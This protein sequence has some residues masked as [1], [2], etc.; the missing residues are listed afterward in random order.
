MLFRNEN[1]MKKDITKEL[2]KFHQL[3]LLN[4]P[5]NE[6][7]V[8]AVKRDKYRSYHHKT[9]FVFKLGDEVTWLVDVRN[10]SDLSLLKNAVTR[11]AKIKLALLKLI[12]KIKL[13]RLLFKRLHVYSKHPLNIVN[14]L[15][16]R[17]EDRFSVFLGTHAL[18]RNITIAVVR[19]NG[20]LEYAK[21]MNYSTGD[22]KTKNARIALRS[23]SLRKMN[24]LLV[25]K[26]IESEKSN[27]LH[28][29]VPNLNFTDVQSFGEAHADALAD[30]FELS[31]STS[32]FGNSELRINAQ[33]NLNLITGE[34]P[35]DRA[36][37]LNKRLFDLLQEIDPSKKIVRSLGHGDFAPWNMRTCDEG[38][39]LF[40][41]EYS[42]DKI[43]AL[44]DLIHYHFQKASIL[45][46]AD[47]NGLMQ[48][49]EHSMSF[50][51]IKRITDL[52]HLDLRTYLK[53]Y[54]NVGSCILCST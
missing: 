45:G 7:I 39:Y 8:S 2:E 28:T 49:I 1:N 48:K 24:G 43:P 18:E 3:C 40:D 15:K 51:S 10:P 16:L 27:L 53:Y 22:K 13:G 19:E 42:S 17:S 38:L 26:L 14:D 20:A 5:D 9:F 30:L 31:N 4:N 6:I 32:H 46:D 41:W 34:N 47:L 21:Y 12:S 25:P 33:N 36:Q 37:I 44:F 54:V 11:R 35:Y 29:E 23:I 50:P 52:Y